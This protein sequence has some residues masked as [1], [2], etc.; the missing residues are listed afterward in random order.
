MKKIIIISKTFRRAISRESQ[1]RRSK[2][3]E[4][5]KLY[6]VPAKSFPVNR[7]FPN[8]DGYGESPLVGESSNNAIFGPYRLGP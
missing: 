2:K 8:D 4:Q 7:S 3:R 1:Y 5:S 6:I